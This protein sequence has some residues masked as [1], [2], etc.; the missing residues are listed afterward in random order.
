[1]PNYLCIPFK[2]A[3]I[4]FLLFCLHTYNS[5][6]Q[7]TNNN[8]PNMKLNAAGEPVMTASA[9]S[10]KHDF[11][12]LLGDHN[13]HHKKLK[14]R[15][16]HSAEWTESDGT[17]TMTSLLQGTGNLE[18]H[19]MTTSDGKPVEGAAMRLFDPATRLWSI[20]W[21]DSNSGKMDVPIVGS[22]ENKIGYFFARDTFKGKPILLQ[23][24]WDTTD[25]QKPVW[26]QAFSA[27]QGK[28][29]EWNWYMYFSP[30]KDNSK[31]IATAKPDVNVGLLELRN[32]V[33]QPGKRDAFINYFEE[34]LITP[35]EKLNGYPIG[36]FKVKGQ[37]DNLCW[38]RG[39]ESFETRSK[40]LPA[41][42]YGPDWKKHKSTAN[43]MLANNDNV[44]LLRPLSLQNDTL[45]PVQSISSSKLQ[46]G[47][48]IAVVELY[49][50]NQKLPDLLKLF[51]KNYLPAVSKAGITDYTLWESELK[52]NDFPRLPV[53]QDKNLLVMITF[54]DDELNYQEKTKKIKRQFDEAVNAD[55]QNT[56]TLKSTW[57]LYPT[58]NTSSL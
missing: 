6:C 41:F 46:P 28:T 47:H 48:R 39:F 19:F 27:D 30:K 29:W 23:F 45:L 37:E 33:M 44:Y 22:F 24:K 50:A 14:A 20:Y 57:I 52:E 34:N 36:E 3:L 25:P 42:Y 31:K 49:T 54:Y 13:V 16:D 18:Q 7:N 21:S 55:L 58:E 4:I 1:M 32:Y 9:S 5:F 17:H 43:N 10:S 8:F 53:F 26:S 15:L 35:Q 2:K 40:F 38:L 11:D 56:I 51:A 12:F